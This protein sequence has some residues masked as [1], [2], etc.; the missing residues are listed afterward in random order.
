MSERITLRYEDAGGN[1]LNLILAKKKDGYR[2]YAV[3]TKFKDRVVGASAEGLT[4]KEANQYLTRLE[5]KAVENGWQFVVPVVESEGTGLM[6]TDPLTGERLFRD[7][8]TGEWRKDESASRPP[9]VA[10]SNLTYE[11]ATKKKELPEFT[12]EN[13][14]HP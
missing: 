10:T 13:L 7:A 5:K 1:R 9:A 3:H 8:K 12:L 14:P 6:K 4:L 2:V 11:K